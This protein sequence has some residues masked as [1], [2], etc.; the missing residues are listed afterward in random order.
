MGVPRFAPADVPFTRRIGRPDRRARRRRPD[1]DDLGAVDGQSAR[2]AGR[3][4]RRGRAGDDAGAADR[5]PSALPAR[6]QCGLHARSSIA[7][8]SGCACG[9]GARA[10]RSPAAPAPAPRSSPASAA[11]CSTDEGARAGARR[12][13]D[14]RVE[15]RG[16]A[17]ADDRSRGERVRGTLDGAASL[18]PRR[19]DRRRQRSDRCGGG[20][21]MG[22]GSRM[23]AKEV[24]DYLKQHPKFFEDYADVLAEI[25]VPHP[26]GGHAIPIAE[27]QIL[28]LARAQRR[29]SSRGSANWS[30]TGATTTRSARSCTARRSRSSP[31]PT[32][33]R[34]SP[35]SSTAWRRTSACRRSRRGSGAAC[36]RGSYLAE[37]AAT[38]AE[39][40]AWSDAL[41]DP[42][43]GADA[44]FE[45]RE[46]FEHG[47]GAA[48][49]S[50]SCRCARRRPS[51]CSRSRARTP[52][53][54]RA[55][56]GTVYLVRL[57]ELASMATARYLPLA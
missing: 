18:T 7:L 39:V 34:R 4:R 15:G 36:P 16:R 44:P 26:H 12:R 32:S 24:A 6:R 48:R 42:A 49:R 31:R 47:A 35:C 41:G 40:R 14:G 21:N 38:S 10:R 3:R 19:R 56:V 1:R 53:R 9:S 25:F 55:G 5:A 2:G 22:A 17:G 57:A 20:D 46:W 13:A 43:C 29:T 8:P 11:A 33:R 37:L 51:A 30:G 50:R 27:R 23:D 52:E 45:T 54:F 28:T